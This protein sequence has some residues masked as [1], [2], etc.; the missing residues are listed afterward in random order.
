M[1]VASVFPV[2]QKVAA[3]NHVLEKGAV[4]Q[5]WTAG[6]QKEILLE[7]QLFR[8][9]VLEPTGSSIPNF[10]YQRVSL[11]LAVEGW[12]ERLATRFCRLSTHP[13]SAAVAIAV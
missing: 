1:T 11:S 2:L 13:G 6:I 3:L 5:P 8:Y 7:P 10:P 4:G 9:R 12:D